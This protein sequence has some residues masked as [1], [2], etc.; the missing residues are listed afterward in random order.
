LTDD[1]PIQLAR[2]SQPLEYAALGHSDPLRTRRLSLGVATGAIMVV[3]GVPACAFAGAAIDSSINRGVEL[4]G[5][6]GLFVGGLVGFGLMAV[7]AIVAFVRS[8]RVDKPFMRGLAFGSS[9]TVGVAAAA[10]GIC[11]ALS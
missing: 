4:A 9:I 11:M 3:V 2:E 7:V 8:W 6:A 10:L 5:L 1:D